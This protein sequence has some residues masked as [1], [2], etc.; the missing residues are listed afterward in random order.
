MRRYARNGWPPTS[1]RSRR[2]LD[3]TGEH[4]EM[5]LLAA[6]TAFDEAIER[7]RESGLAWL[8]R[9]RALRYQGYHDEA[10]VAIVR[11]RRLIPTTPQSHSR[12]PD[13]S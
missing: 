2:H 10:E 6:L 8:G 3:A 11:A 13:Y 9:S 1:G 7:D 5:I 4:D 12:A